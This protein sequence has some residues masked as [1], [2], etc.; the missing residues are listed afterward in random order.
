MAW[1]DPGTVASFMV[2]GNFWT[3]VFAW[4][5]NVDIECDGLCRNKVGFI[6][7]LF[8]NVSGFIFV[9]ICGMVCNCPS[10]EIIF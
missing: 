8:T 2:V 7:L 4:G 5:E 10:R 3:R 9:E 6:R 1:S